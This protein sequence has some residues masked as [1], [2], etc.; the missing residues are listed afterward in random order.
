MKYFDKRRQTR[1]EM[2]IE[3]YHGV[4]VADPY[5]WLEDDVAPEVVKWMDEQNAD[6][7][8]Y[9]AQFPERAQIKDRITALWH[10]EKSGLPSFV[11]GKWYTWRNSGLQN[12]NV[13]YCASEPGDMGEVVLDPNTFSAD[14]TVAITGLSYSPLGNF[15]AYTRSSKGSDWQNI[16]ILDLN[17]KQHLPDILKH[18]KFT[19]MTWLADE[20]GFFYSRFPDPNVDDVLKADARN[21]MI[22]LHLLGAEQSADRL[23]HNN[24]ENPDHN[25]SVFADEGRKW[26]FMTA[27]H[28]TLRKNPLYYKPMADLDSPWLAI[29][30]NFDEANDFIEVYNDICYIETQADAPMGRVYSVKLTPD[31]PIDKKTVIAETDEMLTDTILLNEHLLCRYLHHAAHVLK[32]YDLNGKFVKDIPLP[33]PGS[34]YYGK[35]AKHENPESPAKR[36]F[37]LYMQ[38][39]SYLYPASVLRYDPF[40]GETTTHFSAKIDFDFAAYETVQEFAPSKDGTKIPLFI[41]RKKGLEKNGKN[42]VLLYGYGGFNVSMTPGFSATNLAWLE[43]GGIYAVACL[44]GGDEYGEPWHRAGMLESKQN[45]FD[46]FI[47][48]GEYLI[49]EGYTAPRHLGIMGGS[50]GG[51]LTGAC[52]VQRPDLFGAVIVAVPVLDMLRYHKFT[53]GRYWTGEYGCADDP[54]EFKFLYAYS[55]LHNVKTNTVYPPTL[56]MTADTDDRVVPMQARKFAATLHAADA[57]DNPICIR[58]EKSAGHGMGKPTAKIIESSADLFTFLTANL[59]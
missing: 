56:I 33:A 47:G 17:T 10:Y 22:C 45:V 8:G 6:F 49:R 31:G 29:A 54:E 12:Q 51:L 24:P 14:G 37:A 19:S 55:P 39:S 9:I 4:A 2:V 30:D 40:S 25:F 28:G 48:C 34:C 41:T 27:W 3:D 42:P 46:D 38:F 15:L 32:L 16:H 7:E 59:T 44:R 1:R 18:M 13:L 53:A 20:S 57:G 5:R 11:G 26:L 36:H 50:N 43:R 35:P 21:S 58:I 52:L 23:I